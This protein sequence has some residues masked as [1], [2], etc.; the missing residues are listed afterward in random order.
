MVPVVLRNFPTRHSSP[1]FGRTTANL[2]RA[3]AKQHLEIAK[4]NLD[5]SISQH[6]FF[7]QKS[8]PE[9]DSFWLLLDHYEKFR[10]RDL[11]AS[12][13]QKS[14]LKLECLRFVFVSEF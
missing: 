14:Q 12:L 2:E 1:L 6:L 11:V 5:R 7:R 3:A 9:L 4:F 8:C 13:T 10:V